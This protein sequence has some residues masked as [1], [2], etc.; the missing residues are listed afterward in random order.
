[1]IYCLLS[2]IKILEIDNYSKKKKGLKIERKFVLLYL[3]FIIISLIKCINAAVLTF[4]FSFINSKINYGKIHFLRKIQI[5]I[6]LFKCKI[7]F[8]IKLNNK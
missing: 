6:Y 8:T 7:L 4:I 1:M 3:L 2:T 5:F